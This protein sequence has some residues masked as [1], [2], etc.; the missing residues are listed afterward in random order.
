MHR[1]RLGLAAALSA[2]ALT[3][4]CASSSTTA[5]QG[6]VATA[7]IPTATVVPS[8]VPS[9]SPAAR[10]AT[11]QALPEGYDATR[12][13]EADIQA[14]L[15]TAVKEHREVLLDFGAD[16]CPDCRALDVMF[17]SGQV[18]PLLA[19]DYLVVAVDVGEFNH[20][21]DLAGQYV[22]LQTS[23]IPALVVLKSTGTLRT[24]TNDGAFSNARTM[25]P[26]QVAAFLSRWAPSGSR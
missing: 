24:A 14:A 23:G 2:V 3:A 19:K 18:Q 9:G 13:A 26:A 4:G 16:W 15:A 8:A 17:R 7:A 10:S 1:T 6:P 12:N 5:G 21:L 22:N 11:A 20:N 25:D